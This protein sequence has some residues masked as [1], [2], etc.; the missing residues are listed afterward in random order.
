[1]L[2]YCHYFF[3]ILFL[4]PRSTIEIEHENLEVLKKYIILALPYSLSRHFIFLCLDSLH[5]FQTIKVSNRLLT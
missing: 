3:F 1:M 4:F 2:I 5:I